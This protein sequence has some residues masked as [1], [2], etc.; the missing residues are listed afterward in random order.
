M[1]KAFF[2]FCIIQIHLLD[3]QNIT[4]NRLPCLEREIPIMLHLVK[5]GLTGKY[6]SSS[7][8]LNAINDVNEAFKPTCISFK[9]VNIVQNPNYNYYLNL[10]QETNYNENI[11]L[12]NLYNK[13]GFI[14]VY[15]SSIS[16]ANINGICEDKLSSGITIKVENRQQDEVSLD[17]IKL[18]ARYLGLEYTVSI[19]ELADGSN[20]KSTGDSIDDTP[21]DYG[22]KVSDVLIKYYKNIPYYVSLKTLDVSG[23]YT[24]PMI[25]NYMANYFEKLDLNCKRFTS[26]QYQKL[27]ENVNKCLVRP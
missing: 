24:S 27:S 26:G 3:S 7:K 20:G 21:A 22:K 14:N 17:L 19:N 10:S 23:A 2:L 6:D 18:L 11:E 5:N 25:D 12:F 13:I 9:V 8:I 1:R 16:F 15:T 4:Q